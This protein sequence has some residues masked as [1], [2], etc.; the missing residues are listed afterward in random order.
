MK[1][2]PQTPEQ[3]AAGIL[4]GERAA[5]ARGI[6]LIESQREADQ[7]DA[8]RLFSLLAPG[9]DRVAFRLGVTGSPGAGKSSLIEALGL[10]F[11]N[12][13]KKTAVLAV[14]P[15]SAIS[16][17][18]LLGD[19]TRMSEL[20][21][22]PAAFVRPSPSLGVAGALGAATA[23]AARLCEIAG[24]DVVIIET[25][26]S[27]QGE[28][29]V[30]D[31]ADLVLLLVDPGGGD[32]LQ[33]V[34][35]GLIEM[36]GLIA[37]TKADGGRRGEAERLRSEHEASISRPGVKVLLSSIHDEAMINEL[38]AEVQLIESALKPR[39]HEARKRQMRSLAA[40]A[41]ARR[42]AKWAL[43]HPAFAKA[44]AKTDQGIGLSSAALADEIWQA[45]LS[46]YKT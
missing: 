44:I 8:A 12:A 16:G 21:H 38:A 33:A 39:L 18:S 1:N 25:V 24:F 27:G 31:A 43:D 45:I 46:K 13:G 7:R 3:I 9:E 32:G 35:R 11:C 42:A 40:S 23:D 41:L 34:K 5:L 28:M 2:L 37:I 36:A 22:H 26:G 10:R 14:D 29:E 6:T 15:S 30:S 4:G 20:S 17:G 19:K